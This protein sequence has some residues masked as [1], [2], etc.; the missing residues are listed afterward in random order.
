MDIEAGGKE[1]RLLSMMDGFSRGL[2]GV[3]LKGAVMEPQETHHFTTFPC[4][5]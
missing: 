5:S 1:S 4:F 3:V 2:P